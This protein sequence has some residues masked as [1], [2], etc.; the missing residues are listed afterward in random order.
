MN[1]QLINKKGA[2]FLIFNFITKYVIKKNK[3]QKD[4]VVGN[5][6]VVLFSKK[7][8]LGFPTYNP[9]TFHLT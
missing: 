5:L 3:N 7:N 4:G 2:K 9:C 8:N 6:F 1:Y